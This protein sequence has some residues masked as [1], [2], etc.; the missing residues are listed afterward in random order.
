MVS[1][2]NQGIRGER[3]TQEPGWKSD[4]EKQI[5]LS[6][7]KRPDGVYIY[8]R[9]ISTC[10]TNANTTRLTLIPCKPNGYSEGENEYPVVIAALVGGFWWTVLKEG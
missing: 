1:V 7:W 10:G 9:L 6:G 4:M 8:E 2:D 5:F 3:W